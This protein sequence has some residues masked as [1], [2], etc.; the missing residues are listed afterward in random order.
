MA[1]ESM[2]KREQDRGSGQVRIMTVHASKG[3]EAPVV[4]LPDT[5]TVPKST[6]LPR[7]QWD[8]DMPFYLSR[9]PDGG[10]ARQCWDRARQKQLEE[11]RRL[12]YVALTRA[13][14]HLYICGWEPVRNEQANH[15]SWYN[16]IAG[17]LKPLHEPSSAR[18]EN[19]QTDTVFVD[20]PTR[21]QPPV[22][23]SP[24]KTRPYGPLPAFARVA[25]L[26]ETGSET[27]IV[28]S[29]QG[30]SA[31]NPGSATPDSS[32]ARGRLIHRLLQS[33]PAVADAQRDAAAAR[34]LANPQHGLTPV[35]QTDIQ[36][37]VL[38]LLRH[39]EH[40]P[41]FSAD[42]RAEVPVVGRVQGVVVS[43]QI[44]RLCLMDEAVWIIDY[45]TNRPPPHNVADVPLA[46]R[47][48]L[49]SYRAV[50]E[51]IYPQKQ[52]RCFLLWTYAPC[53]MEIPDALMP[54][55]LRPVS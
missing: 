23:P 3:L 52:I 30:L 55:L 6:D 53:L 7:L 28:P 14:H 22:A 24:E 40:A 11:Y 50:L 44:D 35:Q 26:P 9:K 12:M 42:S 5:A 18:P 39:P 31:S 49:S 13:A 37:E 21:Q 20:I 45:K 47:Q 25:L 32:Y 34:F 33:L 36:K 54:P 29:L 19:P 10:V 27:Y 41:I 17:A 43:G 2:I 4:F 8:D 38:G 51:A 15:E 46:Y 16:L 1:T 48:Q